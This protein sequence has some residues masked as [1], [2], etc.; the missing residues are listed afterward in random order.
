M[1][2]FSQICVCYPF[3]SGQLYLFITFFLFKE[4]KRERHW[5]NVF[6]FHFFTPGKRSTTERKLRYSKSFCC[7]F[8]FCKGQSVFIHFIQCYFW[9]TNKFLI[10]LLS[11]FLQLPYWHCQYPCKNIGW[12]KDAI[13]RLIF[14]KWCRSTRS[15]MKES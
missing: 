6:S 2:V 4:I 10:S 1:V 5:I 7:F 11:Y 13:I 14:C 15:V 9:C 8:G 3:S 12:N